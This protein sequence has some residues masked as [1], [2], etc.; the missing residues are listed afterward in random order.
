MDIIQSVK[1]C[2]EKKWGAN[3]KRPFVFSWRSLEDS[4]VPQ[5]MIGLMSLG[6]MQV[7]TASNYG[8]A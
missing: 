1:D 4:I 8:T 2:N 5:G 6:R 7:V 3:H